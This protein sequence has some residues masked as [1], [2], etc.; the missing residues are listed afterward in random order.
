MS[1]SR[2]SLPHSYPLPDPDASSRWGA[3]SQPAR[4]ALMTT[5]VGPSAASKLLQGQEN[6]A[7]TS[8]PEV[9]TWAEQELNRA[10]D[11]WRKYENDLIAVPDSVDQLISG[12]PN[13]A[14]TMPRLF[15]ARESLFN[16]GEKTPSGT[17]V[18]KTMRLVLIPWEDMKNSLSRFDEWAAR[19]RRK[20]GVAELDDWFG[21]NL[22][23]AVKNDEQMY[24]SPAEPGSLMTPRGY[25]ETAIA[26]DGLWGVMLAQT[27]P[28]AGVESKLG[29]SP[30]ALTGEGQVRMRL[31]GQEVDYM[32]VFEWIALTLQ[33]DP[34][35]LSNEDYSWLLANRIT[36]GGVPRAAY[37]RWD[38]R[39]VESGFDPADD[40]DE[41]ARPRL[42]VM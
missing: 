17:N 3:L 5:A 1:K 42:A 33:E 8:S 31:A 4:K 23:E 19:L 37:G 25:L 14:P 26:A 16:S 34:S 35:E 40:G 27:S 32:G 18:G 39:R 15:E 29:K 9:N 7:V 2:E 21:V 36:I 13:F 11:G 20:Q 30:D 12:N 41:N 6:V 38:V 10:L 24:R 28:D 22:I